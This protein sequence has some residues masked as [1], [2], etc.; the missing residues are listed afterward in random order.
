MAL[1]FR[2]RNFVFPFLHSAGVSFS[3][4]SNNNA[5]DTINE[6]TPEIDGLLRHAENETER[7]LHII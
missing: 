2:P 7:R 1:F 3:R 5:S 6:R 4:F